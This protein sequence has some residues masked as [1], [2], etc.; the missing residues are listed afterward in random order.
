VSSRNRSSCT[1]VTDPN[2]GAF[3]GLGIP[4][5]SGSPVLHEDGRA[6]GVL[7]QAH[8]LPVSGSG[9]GDNVYVRLQPMMDAAETALGVHLTLDT[10]P[11]A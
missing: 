7:V 10:D 3:L 9:F 8:A 4:G 2:W 5:D 6:L 1:G 11:V